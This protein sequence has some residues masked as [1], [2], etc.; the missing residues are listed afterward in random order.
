MNETSEQ[1]IVVETLWSGISTGTERL[2]WEGRMPD[3]PGMG[4]PLV[5]GYETVG[6]VVD[7]PTRLK[8]RIGEMV[9]VPGC[10]AYQDVRGLFGGAASHLLTG[11]EK[12]FR[13]PEGTEEDAV[14]LA[15]AAT[16]H[17]ALTYNASR[18]PNL[19]IG[20]GIL[21]RLAAR[22]CVSLGGD[23]PVI[24]EKEALHSTNP[25]GFRVVKPEEDEG[26]RYECIMDLSGDAS[27]LDQLIRSL[28]P[29]GEIVLAGFYSKPISFAFPPAFMKEA[30]LRIAAEWQQNDLKAIRDLVEVK[31]L[32]LTGLVSHRSTVNCA[33]EAYKTAFENPEC[34]KMVLNW[35]EAA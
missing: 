26:S 6:R 28:E 13:V 24:W 27:L 9:F 35:K 1:P 17:H 2:L 34:M 10:S 14:L 4:Y 33:I 3:F 29:G 31:Q 12:A 18:L 20:N 22:L 21:G 19:I 30:R 25:D 11:H 8:D 32:S 16:A 23:A 7:A 5:P 15:L